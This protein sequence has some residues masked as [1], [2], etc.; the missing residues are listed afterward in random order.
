MADNSWRWLRLIAVFAVSWFLASIPST[1]QTDKSQA[2]AK[3]PSVKSKAVKTALRDMR[4]AALAEEDV[5][6]IHWRHVSDGTT[7]KKA[8]NYTSPEFSLENLKT[9]PATMQTYAEENLEYIVLLVLSGTT[10]SQ[11]KTAYQNAR[12]TLGAMPDGQYRVL[13][14]LAGNEMDWIYDKRIN[15]SANPKAF[16]NLPAADTLEPSQDKPG[17]KSLTTALR[18][19]MTA[20]DSASPR[21]RAALIAPQSFFPQNDDILKKLADLAF[22][23]RISFFPIRPDGGVSS[24]RAQQM[25]DVAGPSAGRFLPEGFFNRT[26]PERRAMLTEFAG[27]GSALMP[28]A[29]QHQYRLPGEKPKPVSLTINYKDVTDT[30]ELPH[31][32]PLLGD[33]N[34]FKAMLNPVHWVSWLFDSSRW[35][36]GLGTLLLWLLLLGAIWRLIWP[37]VKL[38]VQIA[39]E[40]D[41]RSFR[42][43][44]V[45]IGRGEGMKINLN[46]EGVSRTHARVRQEQGRMIIE[47]LGSSNGTWIGGEQI[48]KAYISGAQTVHIGPVMLVLRTRSGRVP[49]KSVIANRQE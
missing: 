7:I 47:D 12:A 8:P 26:L 42:R 3:E 18:A 27:G 5:V 24:Q 9:R 37:P 1:A 29:P 11:L 32:R 4:L 43:L 39:G 44:P 13:I 30:L 41:I 20:L 14:G 36:Y 38:H 22:A 19:A 17:A 15:T 49:V 6:A 46:D 25:I 28:I 2:Q 40:P 48:K 21:T 23:R 45:T 31:T 34:L 35:F 16:D 33:I 10:D